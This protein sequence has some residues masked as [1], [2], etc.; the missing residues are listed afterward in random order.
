MST[1]CSAV[2]N[3]KHRILDAAYK[4][5]DDEWH[6]AQARSLEKENKSKRDLNM[7]TPAKETSGYIPEKKVG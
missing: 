6:V 7:Y 3:S 5:E 4:P 1:G 2:G